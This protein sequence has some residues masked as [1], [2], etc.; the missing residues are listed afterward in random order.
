MTVPEVGGGSWRGLVTID[1]LF[2][3]DDQ[4]CGSSVPCRDRNLLLSLLY[5]WVPKSLFGDGT[6]PHRLRSFLV[7][8]VFSRTSRE[9]RE[10]D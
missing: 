5:V 6:C 10:S 2:G 9:G 4:F 3:M 1:V 7:S 8:E